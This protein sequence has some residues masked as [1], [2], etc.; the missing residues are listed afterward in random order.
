MDGIMSKIWTSNVQIFVR[1]VSDSIVQYLYVIQNKEDNTFGIQYARGRRIERLTMLRNYFTIIFR[2]FLKNKL[3]TVIHISGLSLGLVCALMLF[4]MIRTEYSFDQ[5]HEKGDRLYILRVTLNLETGSYTAER[6][7]D[8]FGPKIRDT[9]PEIEEFCRFHDV[10]E[11]L[12]NTRAG[13]DLPRAFM[14]D[15]GAAVDTSFFSL[16]SFPLVRGNPANALSDKFS[17]VL[18]ESLARKLFETTDALGR[19]VLINDTYPFRVTGVMKDIP[20][21]S[22]MQFDFLIPY[23]FLCELNIDIT[24]YGG[25]RAHNFFLLQEGAGPENIN[26][27]LPTQMLEWFEP[28][29]DSFVFLYPFTKIHIYGETYNF[30]AMVVF[31]VIAFLILLIACINYTNMSTARFSIRAR[32]VGIRKTVGA[33][34]KALFWQFMGESLFNSFIAMDVALLVVELILPFANKFLNSEISISLDKPSTWISMLVLVLFTGFLGGIYPAVVMSSFQPVQVMKQ[35][36]LYRFRKFRLRKVLIAVQFTVAIAFIL[37]V[38]FLVRQFD[39]MKNAEP[40]FQKENIVFFKTRGELWDHYDEFKADMYAIPGVEKVTS[41]STILSEITLGEFEWGLTDGKQESLAWVCWTDEGFDEVFDIDVL[42][43]E[44]YDHHDSLQQEKG[45]VINQRMQEFLQLDEP[46]GEGFYLYGHR[47]RITGVIDNFEFYP[48][49]LAGQMLIMPYQNINGYIFIS[50]T[51]ENQEHTIQSIE[52][53]H[54]QINP[55]YPFEYQYLSEYK[56]RL[57]TTFSNARHYLWFFTLLSVFISLLGLFGLTAFTS[58]LKVKEAGI[59]KV[60]GATAG[61]IIRLFTL[62]FARPVIISLLI[63]MA[64]AY[65]LLRMILQFFH[66]RTPLSWWIFVLVGAGVMLLALITVIG[67]SLAASRQRPV[68]CLRYE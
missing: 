22:H 52:T 59:R 62:E 18:N 56:T 43:G 39:R 47:Y 16:F 58:S 40:G 41:T 45:I 8:A 21:N 33:D 38:V 51:P 1:F 35:N 63:G 61:Q 37:V 44:F 65:G 30:N 20:E 66:N 9:Y 12:M 23:E 55:A 3:F 13:D 50:L 67:H 4:I 68:D 7:G 15:H 17:L 26:A 11:L 32:E 53:V 10:D 2:S 42:H 31:S 57:Q 64:A 46:I 60:F 25:Q 34:R 36:H 48:I 49:K 54:K 5:F 24:H 14:E 19:E 29:I 6:T 27:S 28:D